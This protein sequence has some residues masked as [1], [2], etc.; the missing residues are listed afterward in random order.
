MMTI[1]INGNKYEY[2]S[3]IQLIDL[4]NEYAPDSNII[5][6]KVDNEFHGLNHIL[7]DDCTVEFV[8][9]T[10]AA[11]HKAYEKTALMI[12]IKA[13][14]DLYPEISL[15]D[16]TARF[17]IGNGLY[18]SIDNYII[19]ET[20]VE[21]ISSRMQKIVD[22]AMPV[23]KKKIRTD[24][25]IKL[26]DHLGMK[27]KTELLKYR[28]TSSV[29]VYMLGD[30]CDYFYDFVAPNTK[31]I[32]SFSLQSYQD[33]IV[34]VTPASS[35][36][37]KTEPFYCSKKLFGVLNNFATVMHNS[38]F[39]N[40][41]DLNRIFSTEGFTGPVLL[42]E[43]LMEKDISDIAKRI[44]SNKKIK[45]VLIAGPSSSGKTT[46]SHRLSVQ[47]AAYGCTAK[48]VESDNYFV[49]REKTPRDK[50]GK[51]DFEALE[52]MDVRQFA[53]DCKGLLEGK[54]VDMPTFNFK[55]G[56][57]E[58][59]GNKLSLTDN[60]ILIAE[61]IHCLDPGMVGELPSDRVFKIYIAPLAQIN[62][63]N[64]NYISTDDARLIRRIVRDNRKRS[65]DASS[66]IMQWPSVRRGEEKYIIP[67]RD[68]ADFIFNSSMI[69]ELSTIKP[70]AE[71][72]LFNIENTDPAY[73]EAKRLLK[74]LDYFLCVPGSLVPSN[75]LLSEFVGG[76]IFGV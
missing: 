13:I 54:T 30:I 65:Y 10:T 12:F 15:N 32:Y 8:D 20:F 43:A 11:G 33:G 67:F 76:N 57:R 31:Y 75:S 35:S 5:L 48:P 26:F 61:G 66:T 59:K 60:E 25:A 47:L 51:P 49:D 52:A 63:D 17:S 39:S 38:G 50:D 3:G 71:A 24:Q 2:E 1:T 68:Q 64:H 7:F 41:S 34:L 55:T 45:I 62:I 42:Q 14:H 28:R 58:Y 69:Y 53:E 9:N 46:F 16:V 22:D 40:V 19:D 70:Y 73:T 4:V 29:S 21:N 18:I 72:L 74:L 56:H 6:C 27:D 36:P 23:I 44:S 37:E